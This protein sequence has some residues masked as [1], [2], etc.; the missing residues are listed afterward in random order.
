MLSQERMAH[1]IYVIT[2]DHVTSLGLAEQRVK[3]SVF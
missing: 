1:R 3:A 2:H